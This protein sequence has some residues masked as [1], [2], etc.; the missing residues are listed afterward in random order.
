MVCIFPHLTGSTGSTGSTPPCNAHDVHVRAR[1]KFC[2]IS[3]M[4]MHKRY[5]KIYFSNLVYVGKNLTI[6]KINA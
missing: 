2:V 1:N 6:R 4:Y 5:E 3:Y